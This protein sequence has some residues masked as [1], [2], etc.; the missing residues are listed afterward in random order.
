MENIRQLFYEDVRNKSKIARSSRA[1]TTK[2]PVNT[3]GSERSSKMADITVTN[4]EE[5][6]ALSP[7]EQ[8]E[9]LEQVK[10]DPGF[11][12]MGEIL[13]LSYHWFYDREKKLIKQL[14]K[15]KAKSDGSTKKSKTADVDSNIEQLIANII[16]KKMKSFENKID[17]QLAEVVEKLQAKLDSDSS[18]VNKTIIS[19][20]EAWK[21]LRDI[22]ESDRRNA[23]GYFI[24]RELDADSLSKRL[25]KLADSV[26][27]T[28][29]RYKVTISITELNEEK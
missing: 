6:N 19:L 7:K 11:T 13:G 17:K 10:V 22:I 27:I 29:S 9:W 4:I 16:E 24:N 21:E 12:K 25:M 28:D 20:Q 26:G 18:S 3:T 2:F 23:D 1:V 14:N 8:L 15:G 5:Y